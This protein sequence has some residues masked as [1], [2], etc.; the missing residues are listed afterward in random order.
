MIFWIGGKPAIECSIRFKCYT[1]V[2]HQLTLGQIWVLHLL[3]S[4]SHFSL[5]CFQL[6][7]YDSEISQFSPIL[8]S[9]KMW[10][11]IVS[12]LPKK[13][14]YILQSLLVSWSGILRKPPCDEV[15]SG[16]LTWKQTPSYL[17]YFWFVPIDSQQVQIEG[18]VVQGTAFHSAN[19]KKV[20]TSY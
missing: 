16:N 6:Q 15:Q 9:D 10:Q 11:Y 20:T 18:E 4:L 2:K 5:F 19:S 12:S 7:E 3:G 8:L 14:W 1:F 13:N 17:P